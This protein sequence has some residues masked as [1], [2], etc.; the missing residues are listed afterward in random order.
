MDKLFLI[1]PNHNISD[2]LNNMIQSSVLNYEVI[3]IDDIDNIPNLKNKKL[4]FAIELTDMG[5]D[6]PMIEFFSKLYKISTN[7]LEGS[8]GAVLVHSNTEFSTKRASQDL[9][10]MANELGCKFIGHPLIEATNSLRNFKT[11][12]NIKKMTL[13]EI[14]L[15]MCKE[16]SKRLMEYTHIKIDNPNILVLYSMPHKT[17]N[18]VDLWHMV[19]KHLEDCNMKELQIESGEIQ[20]CRGCAYKTCIHYAE[21]NKC[22][23]GGVMVNEVL[24]SIEKAD[25]LVLLCPNYNDSLSANLTAVINR[26][27][28]LYRRISF[29]NKSLFGVIVSG[30]SGSDSVAKQLIGSLTIN[31]GFHLPPDFAITA[32]ANDPHAIFDVP[33]IQKR[34]E[35]FALSIKNNI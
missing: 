25:A 29:H 28:V 24:P 35:M 22:F 3:R 32:I 21:E 33:N 13:Q 23:Y 17:S 1:V 27:T 16:L 19:S 8:T 26:L 11:W 2:T 10:F 7:T 12:Q 34:A 14:C 20:D 5:Y 6:I 15:E 18:T 30:N 31:K 4:I 9:I